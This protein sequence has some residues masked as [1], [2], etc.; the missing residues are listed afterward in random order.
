MPIVGQLTGNAPAEAVPPGPP[1]GVSA[2]LSGEPARLDIH[3][4]IRSIERIKQAFA[5]NEP[6]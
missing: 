2:S 4:P 1:I 3:V 6:M 5:P